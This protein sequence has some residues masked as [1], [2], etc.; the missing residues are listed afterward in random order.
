MNGTVSG[1]PKSGS[2]LKLKQ[3]ALTLCTS[4]LNTHNH[5]HTI[6]HP[7]TAASH[8]APTSSISLLSSLA[9]IPSTPPNRLLLSPVDAVP[10]NTAS[11]YSPPPEQLP[12]SVPVPVEHRTVIDVTP[13]L[14]PDDVEMLDSDP[15]TRTRTL[16]LPPLS[17][18]LPDSHITNSPLRTSTASATMPTSNTTHSPAL[19]PL[20]TTATTTATGTGVGSAVHP[21]FSAR[22]RAEEQRAEKE[23]LERERVLRLEQ[24]KLSPARSTIRLRKQQPTAHTKRTSQ[25][26]VPYSIVTSTNTATTLQQQHQQHADIQIIDV[27]NDT[28]QSSPVPVATKHVID[29]AAQDNS[30]SHSSHSHAKS[31]NAQPGANL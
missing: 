11:F 22:K 24:S 1:A 29:I 21:F 16:P 14:T 20:S 28:Y 12:L 9:S 31:S 3:T 7:Q 30:N 26:R 4:V 27:T 13:Q 23:R 25:R 10:S 2:K 17:A 18:V 19:S 5:T 8:G 15:A 6:T